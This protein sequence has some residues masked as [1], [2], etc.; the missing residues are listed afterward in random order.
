MRLFA[1]LAVSAVVLS[2]YV[3]DP[4]GLNL[5]LVGEIAAAPSTR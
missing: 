2:G 4:D 1:A 3:K 5:E